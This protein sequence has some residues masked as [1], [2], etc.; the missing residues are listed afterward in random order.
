MTLYLWLRPGAVP[1]PGY[2]ATDVVSR[3]PDTGRVRA[4]LY[5]CEVAAWN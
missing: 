2:H 4:V 3:W 5:E 1:P